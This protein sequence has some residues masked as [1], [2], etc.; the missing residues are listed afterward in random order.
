VSKK[1]GG[2]EKKN[3]GRERQV[4]EEERRLRQQH[5]EDEAATL[6]ALRRAANT[7]GSASMLGGRGDLRMC[8]HCKTGPYMNAACADL[9]AHNDSSTTYKGIRVASTENPNACVNCG[10]F[11]ADWRYW[12]MWDGI[13]GPH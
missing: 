10:W 5:A 4:Q 6:D 3:A 2:V 12:P 1:S 13:E 8:G 7:E 9:E 11:D